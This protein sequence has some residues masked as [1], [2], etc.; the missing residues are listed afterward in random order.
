MKSVINPERLAEGVVW[1]LHYNPGEYTPVKVG[2]IDRPN[3]KAISNKYL[4]KH[5]D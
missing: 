4:L 1:H 3:F 5:D 2:P